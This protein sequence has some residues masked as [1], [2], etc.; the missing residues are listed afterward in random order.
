MPT[1]KDKASR[2]RSSFRTFGAFLTS[3]MMKKF[4]KK[5]TNRKHGVDHDALEAGF[6][7]N[8][9]DS[10]ESGATTPVTSNGHPKSG[11]SSETT[12]LSGRGAYSTNLGD[13]FVPPGVCGLA[14][15]GLT[16]Y[17]NAIIQCLSNTDLLAEYFV[18][19][20]YKADL[21]N[22]KKERSKKYGT[23]GELAEQFA[24]I[25]RSLWTNQYDASMTRSLKDIMCKYAIQYKGNEQHDSQEYLLW[26]FDKIHEDLNIQ[27][28]KKQSLLSRAS[29]R[30]KKKSPAQNSAK[31]SPNSRAIQAQLDLVPTSF[32]QKVFQAHFRSTLTCPDCKRQSHTMDP[33]LCVSLP[34]TARNTRAIYVKVVF[35]SSKKRGE[36]RKK[37]S[38]YSGSKNLF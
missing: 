3:H 5:K 18:M 8:S 1:K 14:N 26:L 11:L 10:R 17:I 27:P 6:V 36:G 22:A 25:I 23:N 34:I 16:C 31:F 4:A 15:H 38:P 28:V 33:S 20:Q 32:I 19:G 12:S 29:F 7:E 30:K 9:Q 21:K 2:R 35:L 24:V 13:S 37:S